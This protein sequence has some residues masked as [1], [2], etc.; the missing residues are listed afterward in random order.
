MYQEVV[1]E[2]LS[3]LPNEIPFCSCAA[4]F[5]FLSQNSIS[6][7]LTP[8]SSHYFPSNLYHNC[9]FSFSSSSSSCLILSASN[10]QSSFPPI[11]TPF[12]FSCA[13]HLNKDVSGRPELANRQYVVQ[14]RPSVSSCRLLSSS[15]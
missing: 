2:F 7:S 11:H 6:M 9:T 13:V 12:F 5:L 15:L 8:I 10:S 1:L 3:V 14:V 4:F